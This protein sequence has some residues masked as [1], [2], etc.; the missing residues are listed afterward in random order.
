[1]TMNIFTRG[2]GDEEEAEEEKDGDGAEEEFDNSGQEF[3]ADMDELYGVGED[4]VDGG[5]SD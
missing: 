3:Q 4:P 5:A 2:P 1:M